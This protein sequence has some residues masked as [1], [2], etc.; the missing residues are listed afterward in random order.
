MPFIKSHKYVT[1]IF[2]KSNC[3]L[4]FDTTRAAWKTT[5]PTML[6]FLHMYPLPPLSLLQLSDSQTI[7][8]HPSTL[9]I[10]ELK[11]KVIWN[12]LSLGKSV[13]LS[14]THLGP[15]TNF[16]PLFNCFID[17]CRFVYLGRPIWREVGSVVFSCCWASPAEAFSGLCPSENDDHIFMI[18]ELK[19]KVKV[20]L[21]LTVSQS[22]SRLVLVITS[23]LG[24]HGKLHTYVAVQLL[25]SRPQ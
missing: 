25:L 22:L 9:L 10:S 18:S 14:G 19:V 1:R 17:S 12:R 13:L 21:Q 4:S 6:V 7:S 24:P 20:T 3:L 5:L 2:G 11:V 23:G 15:A 8:Q 16:F